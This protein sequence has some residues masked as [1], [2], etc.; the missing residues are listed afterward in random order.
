MPAPPLPPLPPLPEPEPE[1]PPPPEPEPEPE[2]DVPPPSPAPPFAPV[3][4]PD[5]PP[6]VPPDVPPLVPPD[7]PPLVPDEPG[8]EPEPDDAAAEPEPLEAAEPF[9]VLVVEVV[10][11]LEVVDWFEAA[12]AVGTV[13]GGAPAVLV[14]GEP[15]PHAARLTQ[16]A[17]PASAL[18]SLRATVTAGRRG[19]TEDSDFKRLHAPRAVRAVVEV[20]LTELIA[21]VAEAQILDRPRQLGWGG[22]EREELADHLQRLAGLAVDVATTGLCL[23]HDFSPTGWRPHPVPLTKP[24][25]EPPS[26]SSAQTGAARGTAAWVPAHGAH[27]R[28]LG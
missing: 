20:L 21:P 1:E 5:V 9:V 26:Y 28:P 12:V 2:P 7:V 6:L 27:C 15:P 17:T 22:G 8:V 24:H 18:P 14:A 19:T 23:D 25:P 16:A 4:P 11:D 3:V 13:S 10:D